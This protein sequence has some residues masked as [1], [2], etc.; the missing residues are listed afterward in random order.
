MLR[1][2]LRLTA[3]A[4]AGLF[5][6]VALAA[7]ATAG[8]DYTPPPGITVDNPNPEAGDTVTISGEACIVGA[9]VTITFD[10][11]EVAT[12]T[13]GA[14]GTFSATFDIPADTAP[15]EYAVE[16][17]GCGPE[18]L[19]TTLTVSAAAPDAPAPPAT[20]AGALPQ[21]GSSGTEPLVRTGAVLL[22]AGAVLVY[23]V[24]RRQLAGP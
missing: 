13:V 19:G 7:P 15:G 8:E 21:T 5:G 22:A 3:L 6:L 2:A 9:T 1:T 4:I 12:A 17:I 23:A 20:G 10:G 24:R 16:V 14:D 11:K 18:V